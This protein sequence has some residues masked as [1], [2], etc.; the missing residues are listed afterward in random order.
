MPNSPPQE[1][2]GPVISSGM[3]QGLHTRLAMAL[4]VAAV[5]LGLFA[6]DI[7]APVGALIFMSIAVG[8]LGEVRHIFRKGEVRARRSRSTRFLIITRKSAPARFYFYVVTYAVL[9]SFSLIVACF[10]FA[11]LLSEQI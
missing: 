4:L 10:V 9:G 11:Q 5:V 3:A 6:R 8:L 7:T 1:V 2:E